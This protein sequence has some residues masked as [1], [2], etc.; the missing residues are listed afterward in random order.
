MAEVE[1]YRLNLVVEMHDR[2]R[3]ALART[4][5]TVEKFEQ[6]LQRT[7]QAAQ[8]LDRQKIEPMMKVKDSLTASVL[9]ADSLV[10]KL[11]L[12]T[13]SP[14]IAAQDRVSSVATR[15]N[16]ALEALDKGR[17][18]VV[19]DM[20]GPLM[21]EI[22]KARS[23]LNLLD[24]VRAGP[25]A[26]LRG[27]LFGQ[28]TKAMTE[29]RKLD[30]YRIDPEA[31]LKDRATWK[32]KEIG[33]A[34]RGLTSRAWTVTIQAKDKVSNTLR[35]IG[36]ALNTSLGMVGMGAATLGP[37]LLLADSVGKAMDF[38]AQMSSIK[39]LTGLA[40]EEMT[41][42][43]NLAIKM[44]AK[45][46]YSALE[47]A[48]GMEELL[49]AG[50]T[51]A[52]VKAGGLEAALNLATAGG[53][54]LADAAEIMS[55][56][57]NAFK[58]DAM[59][60]AQASD[61]LAG[62]ANASATSVE[63]LRYGLA[64]V[65]A[66]ASGIGMSF[67]DTNIA[68]GLFA[69][70]GLKGSDGGTSLKTMLM[71]LQ[72]VTKQQIDMFKK[73]GIVTASGANAF[74]TAE[75]K[76]KSLDDIAGILQG[77]LKGMTD[78]QRMATLETMFG[79]DAIR[80]ANI[81]YK[82]GATGVKKFS[83]EMSRVTALDV[84]KEKMNN[85]AGAVEQFKGALET[86]QISA[87]TPMMPLIREFA[88][89]FADFM[90]QKGPAVVKKFE[91]WAKDLKAF[92]KQFDGLLGNEDMT[93]ADKIVFVLDKIMESLDNWLSGPGG[94][95]VEQ[96]FTK[97][98]EIA[99]R[100]WLS[101]LGGMGKASVNA[102]AE[103]NILGALGTGA[104]AYILGGGAVLKGAWGAGKG[105]YKWSKG[106]LAGAA[107]MTETMPKTS[108]AKASPPPLRLSGT[109]EMAEAD[110]RMV[111]M[112]EDMRLN[113]TGRI[114]PTASSAAEVIGSTSVTAA[115]E[116][117]AATSKGATT[118][119]K[120]SVP[121]AEVVAT[122][123][124]L[125]KFGSVASK[126]VPLLSKA[127]VPLA[128]ASEAY[129][130]YKA[131][132]KTKAVAEA[133]GGLAGAWAGGAGGAKMGAIIG[134]AI[135][136]GVGTAVGG[137]LG[138]LVGGIGG[139][140]AGK[141]AAGKVVDG[142]KVN[143]RIVESGEKVSEQQDR[144]AS[145]G[146]VYLD[147]QGR[148]VT[149]N[150][151][152][153][154]SQNDLMSAFTTLAQAVDFAS[155]KLIAFSGIEITPPSEG[156]TIPMVPFVSS[157]ADVKRHPSGVNALTGRAYSPF[158]KHAAGGILTRPHLGMV[159]EAGPEAII[160]LS[161]KMRSRALGIWKEAGEVL[162]VIPH[163]EG[164]IYGGLFGKIKQFFTNDTTSAA[165]DN[166][167]IAAIA[168]ESSRRGQETAVKSIYKTYQKKLAPVAALD[169]V[170]SEK[171]RDI[172]HK[173]KN[174]NK[175]FG[176]VT[177]VASRVAIP[178][179]LFSSAAEI[180]AAEDKKSVIVKELGST[181][182]AIGAGALA[183][184][185]TGALVGG[186]VLS[187]VTALI[188]TAIG[189]GI[190]A[191]GGQAAASKLCSLFSKHAEGGILTRPHL[192]MVAEAGPEA[193]IPLSSRMRSQ[194]LNLWEQTG[195]QLGVM[196]YA[197]GGFAGQLPAVTN[198][199]LGTPEINLNFDLAGLVGQIIVQG[200]DDLDKS[201]DEAIAIIASRLKAIIDNLS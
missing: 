81:L 103:G 139:Y 169:I 72:P 172:A 12:E 137:V 186:G 19:A 46:K 114:V 22:V 90:E 175:K 153:I 102:L 65:S 93:W 178:L 47:A 24:D 116:S 189:A 145:T 15:M 105:V 198:N 197:D 176:K 181:L 100:A 192:G 5:G 3:A 146:R 129:N 10:K 63:E 53:L 85:A 89:S 173:A 154:D 136:P 21:D 170:E 94:D 156:K 7:K 134:T 141:W 195:R 80:A 128:L 107:E 37:T 179:A 161:S 33:Y 111:K 56:S 96:I 104:G 123:S 200:K 180:A 2:M 118:A 25:V 95:K 58:A 28:L 78:Q 163:A 87:L 91:G 150:G 14:V 177:K 115:G 112:L 77:S 68:L 57:L 54:G 194:A 49:K 147:S 4:R 1:F 9:K 51:P 11:D 18:D 130:V 74:Y 158:Q 182:G 59:T 43:Q 132:D 42:I 64:Q 127:A 17:V 166:S 55:T 71:N 20:K 108:V 149:S 121:A 148:I 110:A 41:E 75:G 106:K 76:L 135:A 44:G 125:S 138:G 67:R 13:A 187:P 32:T 69:N 117:V 61:V 144:I 73:L 140:I 34:L 83:E 23:A 82:E 184:A 45:T 109:K 196:P 201:V 155:A 199:S 133:G 92:F 35:G 126:A 79:S 48:Q 157:D 162:G 142:P 84:A 26:D 183:G 188:G 27:E 99:V 66:V 167:E 50:L 40:T 39:A 60:A 120:A 159:A 70:N 174:L 52:Q 86:L 191:F 113:S 16:A 190:G 152:V 29:A 101:V 193:I 164:G 131:E 119:V 122:G 165:A 88:L 36:G 185:A 8:M 62:T 30:Q 143:E 97:L 38:E 124:K 98:A 171:V 151:F 6:N 31:T 168:L 160:P